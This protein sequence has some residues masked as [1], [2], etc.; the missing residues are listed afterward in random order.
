MSATGREEMIHQ[1]RAM[2]PGRGDGI[3]LDTPFHWAVAGLKEPE[4]FFRHLPSLL[5]A[6]SILYVEGTRI[7]PEMAAFYSVHRAPNAE[8]V[9]RDTIAPVPDIYHFQFSVDVASRLREFAKRYAVAEMFDH[10]KAYQGATLL[11][12]WHDAF[13]NTLRI[14]EHIA[15]ETVARFSQALGVSYEREKTG[16]RD[17]ELLRKVLWS[18]EHPEHP[19]F[20]VEGGSWFRRAWRQLTR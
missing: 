8:D 7:A 4:P 14:S 9:A 19:R 10:F 18:L 13:D 1:L 17:P 15:E 3:D 11:L 20:P 16:R 5:P 2:I 6:D 12:H